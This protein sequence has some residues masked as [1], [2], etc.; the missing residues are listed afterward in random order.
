M[1]FITILTFF[2]ENKI[3]VNTIRS[4]EQQILDMQ[5]TTD[6]LKF[7]VSKNNKEIETLHLFIKFNELKSFE[8]KTFEAT[9]YAPLDPKAIEGVCYS[10]DP[11]ITASG[12]KVQ[13]GITI[14]AGKDLPFGTWLWIENY[15]WRRVD[16][17]GFAIK[18]DKIDI[19]FNTRREALE[20]GRQTITVVIPAWVSETF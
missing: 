1:Y 10:G 15:G 16:D 4:K 11:T 12:R 7:L 13:P 14:A 18:N 2:H 17:R 19:A 8:V 20:F 3:L 6:Y 9:G 5:I